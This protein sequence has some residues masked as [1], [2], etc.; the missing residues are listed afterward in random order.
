MAYTV[1]GINT[2]NWYT[3]IKKHP[4]GAFLFGSEIYIEKNRYTSP[5]LYRIISI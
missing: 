5:H 1:V 2:T 3:D 4:S